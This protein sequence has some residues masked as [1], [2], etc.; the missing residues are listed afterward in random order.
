MK[1]QTYSIV[2]ATL[3]SSTQKSFV[4]KVYFL[5]KLK[6]M[7]RCL[8][9]ITVFLLCFTFTLFIYRNYIQEIDLNSSITIGALLSTLG[10]SIA[11]ISNLFCNETREQFIKNT[12]M[13]LKTQEEF[14][15]AWEHRPFI[16][17]ISRHRQNKG[18]YEYLILENPKIIFSGLNWKKTVLVPTSKNDFYE[19]PIIINYLRLQ[20][21]RKKYRKLIELNFQKYSSE[22]LVWDNLANSYKK[23]ILYKISSFFSFVGISIV[24][25]SFLFSFFYHI[26]APYLNF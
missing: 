9:H 19:L 15:D 4:N 13:L 25:N 11:S 10:T 3:L 22:M 6:K 26:A 20:L 24:V 17:R 8:F 7:I 18:Y 14:S 12:E 2:K 23:I 21:N 1:H 5:F 16:E